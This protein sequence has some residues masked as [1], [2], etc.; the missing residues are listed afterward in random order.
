[1]NEMC[2]VKLFDYIL[3]HNHL[4]TNEL[5]RCALTIIYFQ[6]SASFFFLFRPKTQSLTQLL[7]LR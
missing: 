2:P 1:M 7:E 4:A 3:K 6:L 5:K